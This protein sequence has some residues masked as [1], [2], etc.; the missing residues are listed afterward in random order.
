MEW[1]TGT[2][3]ATS[4]TSSTTSSRAPTKSSTGNGPSPGGRPDPQSP[5]ERRL[6]L[7]RVVSAS[8]EAVRVDGTVVD[9]AVERGLRDAELLGRF[10]GRKPPFSRR[11]HDG[12]F[13]PD[14]TLPQTVL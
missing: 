6:Q 14:Y 3:A 8:A 9:Q 1:N 13:F 4:A 7:G 5:R 2:S 10:G 12:S 11:L